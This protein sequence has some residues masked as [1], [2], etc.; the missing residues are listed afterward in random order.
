M[1]RTNRKLI[2]GSASASLPDSVS[3]E[4]NL[5]RAGSWIE[6]GAAAKTSNGRARV[7]NWPKTAAIRKGNLLQKGVIQFYASPLPRQDVAPRQ[8]RETQQARI[9]A[10]CP[11]ALEQLLPELLFSILVESFQQIFDRRARRPLRNRMEW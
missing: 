2:S 11:P 5:V 4:H 3:R 9:V 7:S 10:R 6:T 8:H 1:F